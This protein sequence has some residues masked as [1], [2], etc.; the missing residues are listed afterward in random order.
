[1]VNVD[2]DTIQII[3]TTIIVVVMIIVVGRNIR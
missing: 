2:S 3:C 1:M